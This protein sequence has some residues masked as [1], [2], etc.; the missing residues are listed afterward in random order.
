[1][2]GWPR[3][4]TRRRPRRL[5]RTAN[6]TRR[7]ALSRSESVNAKVRWDSFGHDGIQDQDR[8]L[9]LAASLVCGASWRPVAGFLVRSPDFAR[10]CTVTRSVGREAVRCGSGSAAAG[11]RF[12][13]E[14]VAPGAVLRVAPH[15]PRRCAQAVPLSDQ[16]WRR[17]RRR[18][19]AAA[20]RIDTGTRSALANSIHGDDVPWGP[21]SV[22]KPF[23]NSY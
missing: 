4:G 19:P 6:T 9:E 14:A 17:H 20:G 10:W 23:R 18:A 5:Q 3:P 8:R 11:C 16:R 21:S 15:T 12:D 13:V 22:R 1:V 7:T 2:S